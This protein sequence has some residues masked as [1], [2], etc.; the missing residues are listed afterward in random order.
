MDDRALP[1]GT[2]TFL[3]T[4]VEGSTRML[5]Q[6]GEQYDE[7]L[8]V[9]RELIRAAVVANGGVEFGTGGD[10]VFVAF[11][12]CSAAVRAAAEAQRALGAHPWPTSSPMKVRMAVHVGEARV[13]DDDY[14][15]M[16]LHVVA[17]LCSAGHGGQVLLSDAAHA[18]VRDAG[19]VELGAHRLRDVPGTMDIF[20]LCGDGLETTFPPLRTITETPNNI[21]TVRDLTVG[22]ELDVLE[23]AEALTQHRL[24]T[25]VGTGGAGKTRLAIEA[26]AS[27]IGAFP[28]G[29]WL[30]ELAPASTADQV[31]ALT[32]RQIGVSER[33]DEPLVVTLGERVSDS[34]ILLVIDN[35]EHLV[36]A[37]ASFVDG[38]LD[39]TAGLR[40]LATSRE[41]LGVRGE[42]AI[43]VSPLRVGGAD[44]PGPAID[45]FVERARAVVPGFEAANVDLIADV[46]RR[47]D[48]LPLAIELAAVRLPS[49][50][51]QQ[52]ANRLD[53]RFRLLSTGARSAEA[54]QKTLESVVVWSYDLLDEHE[55]AA[56]RRL[57]IFPD[58]FTFD[59]AE[60]V[61]GWGALASEVVVDIVTR[62]ADKSLVV[63]VPV[64]ADYRY[65]FLETLRQFGRNQ[66]V[67]TGELD[68]CLGFVH[69]WARS[70]VER[71]ELD[72]RT[73]RQEATLAAVAPEG[74]NLRFVYEA[75]RAAGDLDLALRIV[76]FAPMM[77]LRDRRA[78]IG[79]L[80]AQSWTVR[81][82]LRGQALTSCAQ[83]SFSIGLPEEGIVAAGQAAE[84][85]EQLDD[86]RHEA[87]A[88]YFE[89]FN[90][91]GLRPD[92]EVLAKVNRLI[93]TFRSIDDILGL[94]YL[95][96][97][98]S[99]LEDDIDV[100]DASAAEA[101]RLF[102][103]ISA[104]FG[105]AHDL[106]G[107]ALI[108]IQR[109]DSAGAAR[110]LGEALELFVDSGE[111]GCI[112]HVLEATAAWLALGDRPDDALE[113]LAAAEEL[114]IDSGQAHRPWELRTRASSRRLLADRGIDVDAVG[115]VG[116]AL[117]FATAAAR[118]ARLLQP[119]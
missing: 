76:T 84:I 63:P 55:R 82:S 99:Q 29:V 7:L 83:F 115:P 77:A 104:P 105:L 3:F 43:V 26:A 93:D 38:L 36:E 101:E 22:R 20:Q 14:V 15:G 50:S 23:V 112:A 114:R 81:P 64:G 47:L 31:A 42:Q 13:I 79:E 44:R 27:L 107:R 11:A 66:L 113:L 98:A 70:W 39:G 56:F 91:W 41:L 35:C 4:D 119:A 48:G 89:V 54:R 57:S 65:R 16:P 73:T 25:L 12:S 40:V 88:R 61:A 92:A 19:V 94:A 5:G 17:R 97:V 117:D 46:C 24:V 96:W 60:S 2:V 51:L 100:A 86:R 80:L 32:A 6:L 116:S 18:L 85:F 118:A 69:A 90:A 9:H 72:M 52:L 103:R 59:A 74:E 68:E 108:C 49:M 21:P 95:S 102:R 10:A 109:N 53:D 30:V 58:G 78:A 8:E 67:R 28:D 45:L 62:L 75:A 1:T 33:G 87:W 71:L 34:Q 111:R 106:E 37:V 110:Y